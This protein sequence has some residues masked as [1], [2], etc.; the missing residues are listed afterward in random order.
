MPHPLQVKVYSPEELF[1]Y[2]Q[3]DDVAESIISDHH[4]PGTQ[5]RRSQT[6]EEAL[7]K[8]H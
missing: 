6:V 8:A 5:L 1:V 4:Q 3:N 7:P 2:S